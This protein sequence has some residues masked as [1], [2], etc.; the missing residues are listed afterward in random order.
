LLA[1]CPPGAWPYGCNTPINPW[2]VFLGA[3]PGTSPEP[4]ETNYGP[5][6]PTLPTAGCAPDPITKYRD[7]KGFYEK[8]RSLT[9]ALMRAEAD[10]AME[11]SDALSLSGIMNLDSGASGEARNVTVDEAFARW[12]LDVTIRRLRPRYIVGVGLSGFLGDRRHAWL[13]PLLS[14]YAGAAFM[15]GHA[16][17]SAPFE[18]YTEKR[19][20][21]RAWPL[22]NGGMSPQHLIM[23]PQHPSRAPMTSSAIWADAV[24]ECVALTR[25]L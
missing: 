8:L 2:V 7:S 17:V 22:R 9:I 3:S 16:P 23:L 19:Y 15:P 18:G 4:G 11:V 6:T 13:R 12:S 21:F 20:V 14:G 1:G 5:R 10:Q 25:T 24:R